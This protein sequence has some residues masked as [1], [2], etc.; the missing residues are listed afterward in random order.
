[1]MQ[2]MVRSEVHR[3]QMRGKQLEI[4]GVERLEKLVLGPAGHNYSLTCRESAPGRTL[5]FSAE[6]DGS[7]VHPRGYGKSKN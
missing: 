3:L 7:K 6:T 4:V 5:R 2:D 1:M